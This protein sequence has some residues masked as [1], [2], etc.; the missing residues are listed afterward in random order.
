MIRHLAAILTL[1]LIIGCGREQEAAPSVAAPPKLDTPADAVRSLNGAFRNNDVAGVLKAAL[2]PGELAQLNAQWDRVRSEMSFTEEQRAQFAATM[3]TLTQKDAVDA[4]M[5]M[6]E[7]QLKELDQQMAQ[8]PMAI[9]MGSGFAI[10]MIEQDESLSPEQKKQARQVMEAMS[11]WAMKT[12]FNDRARIRKAVEA[13]VTTAGQLG[14]SDL[15][16]LKGM[17]FDEL[18]SKAG[19]ALAG[20]KRMLE[21]FDF[22]I[23]QSLDSLKVE[24]V[25]EKGDEATV[26]TTLTMFGTPIVSEGVLVRRDGG[27][28]GRDLLAQIAEARRPAEPQAGE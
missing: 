10:A 5:T 15:E 1:A 14:L 8:M 16:Q 12:P 3:S 11:Q 22:S 26:R 19:I 4:I 23:D 25:S 21:A 17:S 13:A 2:P 9:M 24:V 28:Y 7:P 18:L 20:L 27:W 6:L